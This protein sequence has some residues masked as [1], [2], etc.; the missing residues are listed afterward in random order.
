MTL[1]DSSR[2]SLLLVCTPILPYSSV[3]IKCRAFFR[4]TR[5][6]PLATFKTLSFPQMEDD[7]Q[8][9]GLH[10]ILCPGTERN[11][12]PVASIPLNYDYYVR[13]IYRDDILSGF[14]CLHSYHPLIQVDMTS[15]SLILTLTYPEYLKIEIF[16]NKWIW[17]LI[18]NLPFS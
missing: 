7:W 8:F 6:F 4:I 14:Y 12:V 11:K 5:G 2:K 15:V 3:W 17:N 13:T 1:I 16:I 9:N 10:E 18:S